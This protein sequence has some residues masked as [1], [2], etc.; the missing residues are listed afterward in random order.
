[1][2]NSYMYDYSDEDFDMNDPADM[3]WHRVREYNSDLKICRGRFRS[4]HKLQQ[5]LLIFHELYGADID[6][7]RFQFTSDSW[8]TYEKE[9]YEYLARRDLL[10]EET[11]LRL[12]RKIREIDQIDT[13]LFDYHQELSRQIRKLKDEYA[14]DGLDNWG[15]I[16]DFLRENIHRVSDP[17]FSTLS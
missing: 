14:V 5:V 6:S 9:D 4:I 10:T 3:V 12:L 7:S 17:A 8:F 13:Q 1:M 11:S 16:H 15:Q 2:S